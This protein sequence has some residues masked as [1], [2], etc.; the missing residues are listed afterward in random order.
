MFGWWRP[1]TWA[2]QGGRRQDDFGGGESYGQKIK[3]TWKTWMKLQT[4]CIS[5]TRTHKE[6]YKL[7]LFKNSQRDLKR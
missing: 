5:S 4:S 2:A 6:I 1:A 7:H 3:K